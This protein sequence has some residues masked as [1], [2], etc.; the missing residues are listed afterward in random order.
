M[1]FIRTL[2]W[3]NFTLAI[4]WGVLVQLTQLSTFVTSDID[5]VQFLIGLFTGTVRD[6]NASLLCARRACRAPQRVLCSRTSSIFL[7]CRV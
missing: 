6:A 7:S 1:M 4:V 2:F 5:A 3:L